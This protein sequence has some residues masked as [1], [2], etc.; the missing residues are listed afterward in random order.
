M[1]ALNK[2]LTLGQKGQ[3]VMRKLWKMR[4][5]YLML[6]PVLLYF[7]LFKGLK[8]SGII[9]VEVVEWVNTHVGLALLV[10]WAISSVVLL[11]LQLYLMVFHLRQLYTICFQFHFSLP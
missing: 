3:R 10:M 9:P 2:K 5:A 8:S 7:A 4:Y 6:L 1:T 11:L